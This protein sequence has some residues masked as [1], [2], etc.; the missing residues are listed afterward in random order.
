MFWAEFFADTEHVSGEVA[1]AYLYLLGHAW[2]RGAQLPDDDRILARMARVSGGR[3]AAI[4]SDV[5]GFWTRTERGWT[6]KR[7]SKEWFYLFKVREVKRL[8]GAKKRNKINER[9]EH[10]LAPTPTPTIIDS[11]LRSESNK[12]AIAGSSSA[13]SAAD[14]GA[15][16]PE[17]KP[18]SKKTARTA[19]DLKLLDQISDIWNDWAVQ[20]GSKPVRRLTDQR[21]IA[22]RRRIADLM[23]FGHGT[24]EEAFRFLL[25]KCSQSFFAKGSPKAPLKF[26][27]LMREGFMTDMIEGSFDFQP[28]KP[29]A[30]QWAR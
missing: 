18:E 26:D 27:Q 17:N 3:W 22:C 28:P 14:A 5:M 21:A 1:K 7:L 11:S 29:Q 12:P 13:G 30:R 19:S 9:A 6:Q 16:P 25:N 2:L 20:H 10:Q 8:N 4:R 15:A 24:P 23:E